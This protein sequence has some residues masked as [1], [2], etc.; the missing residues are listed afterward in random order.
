[1]KIIVDWDN[2]EANG[3]CMAAAPDVF[4][5]DDDDQLHLKIENP[6]KERRAQVEEA[7]RLC[8]RACLSLEED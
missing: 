3:L 2:C 5:L 1:M 7:I 4:H 8:P 6:S